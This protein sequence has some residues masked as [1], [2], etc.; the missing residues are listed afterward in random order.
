MLID[1][2]DGDTAACVA[3][4]AKEGAAGPRTCAACGAARTGV[5]RS[6]LRLAAW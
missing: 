4:T 6:G 5:R 1:A 3:L 2:P